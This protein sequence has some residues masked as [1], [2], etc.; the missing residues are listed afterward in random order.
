MSPWFSDSIINTP[1]KQVVEWKFTQLDRDHDGTLKRKEVRSFKKLVKR[2]VKPRSCAK[3]FVKFCD[4]D[5]D[6]RIRKNEWSLCLGVDLNSKYTDSE[7]VICFFL[8]HI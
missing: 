1:D 2:M 6:K 3:S 7:F 4:L 8:Y 5:Q